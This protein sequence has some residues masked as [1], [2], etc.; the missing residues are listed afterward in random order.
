MLGQTHIGYSFLTSNFSISGIPWTTVERVISPCIFGSCGPEMGYRPKVIVP[1]SLFLIACFNILVLTPCDSKVWMISCPVF[2]TFPDAP[3]LQSS[4]PSLH[5]A[6]WGRQRWEQ[7]P[8]PALFILLKG[9]RHV[10][11]E[12]VLHTF[13]CFK[14]FKESWQTSA[15]RILASLLL[16]VFQR[17]FFSFL[18]WTR[19]FYSPFSCVFVKEWI[20]FHDEHTPLHTFRCM[21]RACAHLFPFLCL[22]C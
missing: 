18:V 5:P 11:M 14:L 12:V 3:G 13:Y 17:F 4:W 20:Y 8:P 6:L 10:E 9:H 21:G 19:L 22:G 15:K 1:I 2:V 7:A 16:F